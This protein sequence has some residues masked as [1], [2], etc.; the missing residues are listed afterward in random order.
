[1]HQRLATVI[2]QRN[3]ESV[4]ANAVL[5]AEHLESAGDLR[6]AFDWHMRAGAWAQF[7]DF[8]A[9]HA[10]W[11]RARDVADRL[12]VDDPNVTAM[13][14]GPRALICASTW[15][16]SGGIE[17]T[18]FDELRD[19]CLSAG[20]NLSL[21][22]GMAGMLTALIFHNRIRDA[23]RVATDCSLLLEKIGDQTL[24]LTLCAATANAKFQAGEVTEGLRL[25]QHA[26]DLAHG[27]PTI[28]NIVVGSPLALASGLRGSNRL[29][30]GIPGWR[31]DFDRATNMAISID[32]TSHVA[33]ILLRYGLPIHNGASL[34]GPTAMAKTAEALEIAERCGDDFALDAARLSH[35][36]VL[37]NG[38][39][40]HRAAGFALLE[41]YR[42]ACLRHGYTTNSVRYVD[43]EFAKEKA[44][45][46]DVDGAIL[47]A[48]AAVDFLF[49]TGDMTARGP[50][51]TVLVES[52][53]RRGNETDLAE[54]NAAIDRLAAVPVD[55]GFVLHELPLLRLR[56]LRARAVGD[57]AGYAE[58][59]GRYR[60]MAN[61]LDFEGHMAIAA[62]MT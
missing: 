55:A 51:V 9:A 44:R 14:I 5:I 28:D 11:Q 10:S 43:T 59:A 17:D 47:A 19:L 32:I 22:V 33:G 34:P 16:F 15:R 53:L 7:R 56:A 38:A 36:V 45:A 30:L 61:D 40:P 2:Q 12:S 21:C 29:A 27:D 26:I 62:A 46:G 24:T 13:Q 31:D 3:S 1:L 18:G 42:Q 54:A 37:I 6:A 50:A 52:L 39:G 60:T 25:A 20:D 49:G 8:K 57:E 58:F 35:G 48:R 23:A 4:D 41:Q